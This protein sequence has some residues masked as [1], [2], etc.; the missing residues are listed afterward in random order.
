MNHLE[1]IMQ[2][3]LGNYKEYEI[4]KFIISCNKWNIFLLIVLLITH[5][6]FRNL[7]V[8]CVCVCVYKNSM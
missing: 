4:L 6:H 7:Y 2:L 8:C 5:T 3:F 1:C